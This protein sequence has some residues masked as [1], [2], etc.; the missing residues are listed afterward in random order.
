MEIGSE[1]MNEGL[2]GLFL[3]S[4]LAATILPFSSE[5]ILA[6][7]ALGPWPSSTLWLV[8]SAGNWLGGITSY[9]I[10]R[11]GNLQWITRV[12]RMDPVKA[13]ALQAR[14]E[15]YGYWAA[16]LTWVPLIGDPLAVALG[17]SKAPWV[18]VAILMLIGKALRYAVVLAILR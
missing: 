10:G 18:P 12:L 9:G 13:V 7:M 4:F 15:K 3:S 16:L 14:V 5:A 17:L 8:A 2:W 6:A 1:W 11:L